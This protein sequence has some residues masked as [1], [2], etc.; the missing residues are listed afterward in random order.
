ME[1]RFGGI[2]GDT[3]V[4]VVSIQIR[5]ASAMEYSEQLA[6]SLSRI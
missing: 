1:K 4:F 2:D 5:S 6:F 3:H